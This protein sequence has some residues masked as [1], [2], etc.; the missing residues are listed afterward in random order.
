MDRT[1]FFHADLIHRDMDNGKDHCHLE[2]DI[3]RK[4]LASL[5]AIDG[6]SPASLAAESLPVTN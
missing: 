1:A 6:K 5:A 2:S 3:D 4:K